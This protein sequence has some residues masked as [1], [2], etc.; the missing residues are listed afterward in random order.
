MA[1][2]ILQVTKHF[3]S[4]RNR[5]LEITAKS[6]FVSSKT[7]AVRKEREAGMRSD[8]LIYF[9]VSGTRNA[10]LT[11]SFLFIFVALFPQEVL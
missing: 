9:I 4:I 3:L 10:S 7:R 1:L 5:F 6:E 8:I 2:F 11:A